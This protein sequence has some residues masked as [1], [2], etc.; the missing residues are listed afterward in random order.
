MCIR[1]SI[2]TDQRTGE[3]S[4]EPLRTLATFRSVGNKVRF[5]MNATFA[6]MGTIHVGVPVQVNA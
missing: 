1:D 5:G 2:T 6:E 4:K 3:R